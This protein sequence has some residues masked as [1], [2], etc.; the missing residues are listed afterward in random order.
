ML[1]IGYGKFPKMF[2]CR[3]IIC[4]CR[5]LFCIEGAKI[6]ILAIHLN[7]SKWFL[8]ILKIAHALVSRKCILLSFTPGHIIL[9]GR[10]NTK[11]GPLVIQG[12]SILMMALT[13]ITFVKTK[14][15]AVHPNGFGQIIDRFS[16]FLWSVGNGIP[17]T[18]KMPAK[19]A[20]KLKVIVIDK[21]NIFTIRQK[22]LS[23]NK[24]LSLN[25]SNLNRYSTSIPEA[26]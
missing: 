18:S 9:M 20:Y 2:S 8:P 24:N 12:I 10:A 7:L 11:I 6:Y 16:I 13:P 23:H 4:P 25:S 22:K 26:I 1:K 14:N 5:C 15:E 21:S 3:F 19:L 17:F